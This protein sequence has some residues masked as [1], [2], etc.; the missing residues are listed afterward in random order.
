MRERHQNEKN[1]YGTGDD[2]AIFPESL[3]A[4]R[5]GFACLIFHSFLESQKSRA[6]PGI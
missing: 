4:I 1:E 3:E 6:A 5:I 2:T